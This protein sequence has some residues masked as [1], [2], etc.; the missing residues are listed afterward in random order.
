MKKYLKLLS[1]LIIVISLASFIS[2]NRNN[3]VFG[4]TIPTLSPWY[5]G[6]SNLIT[7]RG[8]TSSVQIPSLSSAGLCLKTNSSGTI[9][10]VNCGSG[11]SSTPTTING[12]SG[13]DFTFTSSNNSISFAT[14]S[15]VVDFAATATSVGAVPKPI[16]STYMLQD[17]DLNTPTVAPT[18]FVNYPTDGS[19]EL[20][21]DATN[22]T[23]PLSQGGN[24][25]I[26]IQV[27]SAL[28]N[29]EYVVKLGN[30]STFNNLLPTY[31]FITS[32]GVTSLYGTVGLDPSY[33]GAVGWRLNGDDGSGQY[34]TFS[35]DGNNVSPVQKGWIKAN[36]LF[37]V[38][39]RSNHV[40]GYRELN[41]VTN[42]ELA[43][44]WSTNNAGV[45]IFRPTGL[46]G[47]GVDPTIIG[48]TFQVHKAYPGGAVMDF[49]AGHPNAGAF[50]SMDDS[51]DEVGS[52]FVVQSNNPVSTAFSTNNTGG[53]LA[54]QVSGAAQFIN[55]I[56]LDS[57]LTDANNSTGANGDF[58]MSTG[59][60]TKWTMLAGG[61][62]MLKATYD[63]ANIVEQLVGV[64][65][66][67]TLSNKSFSNKL[68]VEDGGANPFVT[69]ILDVY[70]N[71]ITSGNIFNI[72]HQ[73]SAFVGNVINVAMDG[74]TGKFLSLVN[75][76]TEYAAIDSAGNSFFLGTLAVGKNSVPGGLAFDVN[77]IGRFSGLSDTAGSSGSTGNILKANGDSTYSWVAP[78]SLSLITLADLSN[79]A[80]G[81]TYDNTTGVTSL[82][83]GYE[84]PTTA[85]T[86]YW[87][88]RGDMFK[89]IYDPAG[90][91]QQLVGLTATQ[92]LTNKTLNSLT[93]YIDADA[94]HEKIYNNSGGSLA[95]G[96][97]VHPVVWNVGQNAVEV[98]LA[99]ADTNSQMPAI[100]ITEE[101]I[102]NGG[103][104]ECRSAGMLNG[105]NTN[106]W[107]DGVDLYVAPT[108]GLTST[109]PTATGQYVQRI[110]VVKRQNATN[111]VLNVFGAG[112]LEGTD[113]SMATL[114]VNGSSNF[115]GTTTQT[116]PIN[117]PF[118][119]GFSTD[120][121]LV[122]VGGGSVS[123][124][125]STATFWTDSTRTYLRN[126]LLAST[127]ISLTDGVTNYI[128]GDYNTN[129]F[130]ALTDSSL[131]DYIRYIPYAESYRSGS[132]VHIQCG[133]LY[134]REEVAEQHKR[135]LAT[136]R[137]A[138]ESGLNSITVG[139]SG[140][141]TI[142]GGVIWA[143]PE[144]FT[145][146]TSGTSTRI[147]FNYHSAGVWTS[148]SALNR[149]LN[150]TDYDNGTNL[151]STTD[152]NYGI[153]YIYRGVENVDHAYQLLG[154]ADY[155]S[156]SAA[157]AAPYV[158]SV[159]EL[160]S[161]HA[162]LIGR[163]IYLKGTTTGAIVQLKA[164]TNFSGATA[165]PA[166]NALTGLD[167]SSS[168]HT[169]FQATLGTTSPF[170]IVSNI[171]Q[172]SSGYNIP[173]TSSTTL[174]DTAY[175]WG[176]HAG[177]Y[178]TFS[179]ASSS[180]LLVSASTSL[181]YV[182]FQYASSTFVNYSYASSTFSTYGYASST[183]VTYSYGS[184]TYATTS[185]VQAVIKGGTGTTTAPTSGQVLIGNASGGFDYVASSTFGQA[186]AGEV[187]TA[188]NLGTGYGLFTSKVGVDLQ[189]KSIIA[190]S[191]ITISTTTT[192]MTI[193]AS[194]TGGSSQ[195]T[196]NGND[197]YFSSSTGGV[198]IGTTTASGNVLQLW[199]SST[200]QTG[201]NIT[202]I[203]N[204][205][206]QANI[207][208]TS[209]GALA[210]SDWVATADNGNDSI[211]YVDFG[212]NGSGG[213]ATPFSLADEGYLYSASDDL[214]IAAIG[215]TS[216]LKFYTGN[217][218]INYKMI[219]T[220][221][222]GVA[223]GTSSP[224]SSMLAIKGTST[225][226][227][228]NLYSSSSDIVKF[229][230]YQNGY[231]SINMGTSTIDDSLMVA[232]INNSDIL[233]L[234]KIVSGVYDSVFKVLASGFVRWQPFTGFFFSD[235]D[236]GVSSSTYLGFQAGTSTIFEVFPS[237]INM[238]T[239]TPMYVD[240]YEPAYIPC[241][242][243]ANF[244]AIYSDD[245]NRILV[246]STAANGTINLHDSTLSSAAIDFSQSGVSQ[247]ITGAALWGLATSLTKGGVTYGGYHYIIG[248]ASTTGTMFIKRATSSWAVD[249][250]SISN[251]STST[252]SGTV[253]S[254]TSVGIVGISQ[255]TIWIASSTTI[256]I[257][258]TISTSTNTLT[259]GTPVTITGANM[260]LLN[261]RVNNNG[262]Y[263]G[264]S[265]TPLIRKY[266]FSG[267][268][269]N[270]KGSGKY[271]SAS[272]TGPDVFVM[273]N[274]IYDLRG[275]SASNKIYGW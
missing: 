262:L 249:L 62:D 227:L 148:T 189:F 21:L 89:S 35:K 259:A 229:S 176:N 206:F 102:A 202:G 178:P 12:A 275:A 78:S 153:T 199:A 92:T 179:Y 90:I 118:G 247:N 71:A 197:I 203:Y 58:L 213:G 15:S 243:V 16:V 167:F 186:G 254:T 157:L 141:T 261:T 60:S 201:L 55:N 72:L 166:H 164:D 194:V 142:A 54:L 233:D 174:W 245:I 103:V 109:I 257:P 87:N 84:I 235:V 32:D 43:S 79:T 44:F 158:A 246:F 150:L 137:Y 11:G 205:F 39:N 64:T 68:L 56:K 170:L 250:T 231:T 200:Q 51:L 53:G 230:I 138:I 237:P 128:V 123:A 195:W 76:G 184:S 266:S 192:G 171:L 48:S 57:T 99:R 221:S 226:S 2:F 65:A 151:A 273:P 122:S 177:L 145:L 120:C 75:G 180:Y 113:E 116:G 191:N 251:W 107:S 3:S 97:P 211:H 263:V 33:P 34:G 47:I 6:S 136:N 216:D 144:R 242:T 69:G 129:S 161:S 228:L 198:A 63:P 173:K 74:F 163:I 253:L 111:G 13:P 258:Y 27:P 134:S 22:L 204:G 181:N 132:N 234:Y 19:N 110:A 182:G 222:G 37:N 239:A 52:S 105:V 168:G 5:F 126:V 146:I 232:S 208:N 162:V 100:C 212:I 85:S 115:L 91:N 139:Q 225:N 20:V 185:H 119:I 121:A 81:L 1:L 193:N 4:D 238:A 73:T 215:T 125:T 96:T 93:N 241:A 9:S 271:S 127:T 124:P 14:S 82:T 155:S 140:T 38:V 50:F 23:D 25:Y 272:A 18:A 264:F 143:G 223:I 130:V 104:G 236:Q 256:L 45:D 196:T 42:D 209:S 269:N 114:Q 219:I 147:F 40:N 36:Q 106:V 7:T 108:G 66:T 131:I 133:E 268:L 8:T 220:S 175:G 94:L 188:S 83:A 187:N 169:G 86:S 190:G 210:S 217:D 80:T 17:T 160:I 88:S 240:T 112:Q 26:V 252:I 214:N 265:A 31:F 28:A 10:T 154:N 224:D 30:R 24:Y 270:V 41:A 218:S 29:G 59:T 67:Q 255:N 274:S 95:T 61:G 152:G 46:V 117:S 248:Q 183:F 98:N 156:Q 135:Q 172:L 159:P 260:T 244:Q 207:K 101:T 49:H 149:A 77:G 165:L 70:T 267:V